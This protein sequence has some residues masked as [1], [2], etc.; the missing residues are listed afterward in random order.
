MVV[1]VGRLRPKRG[2]G[3]GGESM[4]GTSLELKIIALNKAVPQDG[5]SE[6]IPEGESNRSHPRDEFR[7]S[8]WRS[9]EQELI[10]L[11]N[12]KGPRLA[13]HHGL[14]CPQMVS[15]S[16]VRQREWTTVV[17]GMGKTVFRLQD[18][19][20]MQ[21]CP[22]GDNIY[23]TFVYLNTDPLVVTHR[24][25]SEAAVTQSNGLRPCGTLVFIVS[26]DSDCTPRIN[27]SGTYVTGNAIKQLSSLFMT[28]PSGIYTA[29]D[30]LA[31][32][33]P[34]TANYPAS[35]SS[36]NSFVLGEPE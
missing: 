32:K 30:A 10:G 4:A 11:L 3:S 7:N 13:A 17:L 36:T 18:E 22:L 14:T 8:L 6:E 29:L 26:F 31:S 2:R 20:T 33:E 1:K 12:E 34:G 9:S 25:Q 24:T 16:T 28:N 21:I 23:M 5:W 19:S 35:P 15:P 27:P